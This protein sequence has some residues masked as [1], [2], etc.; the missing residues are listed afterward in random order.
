VETFIVAWIWGTYLGEG[1]LENGVDV[2][3]SSWRRSAPDTFPSLA[4]AGGAYLNSQLA[5]MEA[6]SAAS[7]RPSCSTAFGYVAEG[8]GQ[9]LFVVRDGVLFTPPISANILAGITRDCVIR[10]AG[11]LGY[12]CARRTCRA[13]SCTLP[14]RRSSP[15]PP[16]S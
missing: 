6:R 10:I 8:T 5:K 11:D 3:V 7:P 13:S 14:T 12:R 4:K 16:P 1:A 2:C 15:A 9:N